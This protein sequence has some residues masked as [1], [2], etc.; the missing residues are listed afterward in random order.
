M[1]DATAT[2][3]EK[4]RAAG[5]LFVG[6]TNMDQFATGLVG[7]RSPYGVP[8]NPFDADCVPGGSSSGSAV[9]VSSGLVSFALGTDTAGSGRVPAGFNNIVGL[10]PTRGLISTTGM[11]PACR[12]VDCVSIFALTVADA[13]SVLDSAAG[14]D[15]KDGFSRAAPAGY[16][17]AVPA[18]PPRFRFGVPAGDGLTFFGNDAAAGLFA[19]AVAALGDMGG[20]AVAIDYAP[21]AEAAALLYGPL[22]A[23]RTA[24]LGDFLA[25][26]A[27]AFH[28]VVRKIVEGGLAVTGPETWKALYRLE[29]LRQQTRPVWSGIDFLLVP[30]SPTIYRIDAVEADPVRLNSN[31]GAYT[32]FVNPMDL[33]AIAV[34]NGFQPDGLPAGVTLIAPAWREATLAAFAADFQDARG[35]PLGATGKPLPE[36]ARSAKASGTVGLAV[37]GAHLSGMALNPELTQIGATFQRAARTAPLYQFIALPDGKR[38]GLIRANGVG[39]AIDIEIWNVPEAALGGFVSRIAPPLGV[40]TLMLEDG[41]AVLGFLCEACAAE[42]AQDISAYGGWRAWRAAAQ[43]S[44]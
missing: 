41:G 19:A 3:V 23:E 25:G 17:P 35:L 26:H 20:E 14:F 13:M 31:L 10:K 22:V 9:A 12:S 36:Q 38:P 21:F 30:T 8:R 5:A 33:S 15:P 40:G 7:I 32:N 2:V 39:A 29:E 28:P 4:L 18:R 37:V 16:R 6:K 34:P 43:R 11:V 42:G 24:A 44:V 27:D 1:P